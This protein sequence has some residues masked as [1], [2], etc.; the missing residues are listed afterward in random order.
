MGAASGL[1]A[2]PC[3]APVFGAV[4]TFVAMTKSATLGFAYLFVFS[5]G[6]CALLVV[7]GLAAGGAVRLPRAGAW[8]V[9]VKRGFALVMLAMAEYYLVQAGLLLI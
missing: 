7:V 6:M 8:M 3:G 4:L 9:W 1:V 2:A 5:L